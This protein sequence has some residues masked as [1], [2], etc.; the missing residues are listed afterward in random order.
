[1]NSFQ[2]Q[3]Y[4]AW[5]IKNLLPTLFNHMTD[6]AI[7]VFL[8]KESGSAIKIGSGNALMLFV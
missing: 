7:V 8:L 1:M 4:F 5:M 2:K 6:I 3:S